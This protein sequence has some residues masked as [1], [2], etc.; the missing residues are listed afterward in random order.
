MGIKE[1]E[2]TWVENWYE[3]SQLNNGVV[4]IGEPKHREEVFCYLVKGRDKDLL[5]DTGMGVVPITHAL[6]KLRNSSKP[7]E[8]VNTHWHFDHTK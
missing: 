5:I 3:I 2:T 4:A 8:V 1:I 6:E 7:L